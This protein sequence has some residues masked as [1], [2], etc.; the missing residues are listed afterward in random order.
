MIT[1][2]HNYFKPENI[3]RQSLTGPLNYFQNRCSINT[4]KML[5]KHAGK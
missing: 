3:E 2:I 4:F 1:D 5:N